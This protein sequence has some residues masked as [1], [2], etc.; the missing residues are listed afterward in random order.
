MRKVVL[1]REP[2]KCPLS[3]GSPS[4]LITQS[5]LLAGLVFN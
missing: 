3:V 4:W 5:A 1:V 2:S